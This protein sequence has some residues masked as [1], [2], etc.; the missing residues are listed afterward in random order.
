MNTLQRLAPLAF[1]ATLAMPCAYADEA[2]AAAHSSTSAWTVTANAT[3]ASQYVSRGFRQTWGKPALQAGVDAVHASG[4]SAGTWVSNVSDRYVENGK[5]EWDLY[6]GYSGAAGPLG[7]SLTAL[8]YRYPGAVIAATGTRYDYAELSAGVSYRWLYA[9]YN[10]TL[11]RDFFGIANARGT[12]YV[13]GGANFPL[14]ADLTLNLHAGEGRV[15]GLGNDYWNWRDI[16][17]GLTRTL[18]AGWSLSA[19]YT[20]AFGA[21]HAYDRY[22]TGVPDGAGRLSV[23]NPAKGTFAV[24]LGRTF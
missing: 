2:P 18:P 3:A 11:T 21:T 13:D 19:A 17:V 6:G 23:S 9:K 4:W 20:R 8:F 24:A 12:G 10:R 15:A 16:K 22:T 7:Y 1:L 5:L 14:G